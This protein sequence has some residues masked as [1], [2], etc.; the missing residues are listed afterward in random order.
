MSDSK[1]F[2]NSHGIKIILGNLALD[3][4][5]DKNGPRYRVVLYTRKSA[6]HVT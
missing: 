1:L 4:P 2:Q 6:D 5:F 3:L